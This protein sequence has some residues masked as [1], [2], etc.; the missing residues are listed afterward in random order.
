MRRDRRLEPLDRGVV[1]PRSGRCLG[2]HQGPLPGDGHVVRA[3]AAARALLRRA[4]GWADGAV[5]RRDRP[6]R[7]AGVRMV[8]DRGAAP[9]GAR[10][11]RRRGR[12][13]GRRPDLAR[14]RR[15]PRLARHVGPRAAVPER[16]IR[17]APC[18]LG[19][20]PERRSRGRGDLRADA[21]AA[22]ASRRAAARRRRARRDADAPARAR[23]RPHAGAPGAVRRRRRDSVGRY[24][25][26]SRARRGPELVGRDPLGP[27]RGGR[28]AP[29][30]ARPRRTRGRL[31]I[32]SHFAQPFGLVVTGDGRRTWRVA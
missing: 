23:A 4:R 26:P 27:R 8:R 6:S 15:P 2:G 14:P 32:A 3:V 19:G 29:A 5:R 11:G 25:E 12:S 24:D 31:W 9:R 16:A 20:D 13:R 1:P 7:G 30:A 17:G 21:P 18:R 22:G 10:R 28:D